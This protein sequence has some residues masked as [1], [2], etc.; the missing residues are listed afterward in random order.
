MIVGWTQ[1]VVDGLDPQRLKGSRNL[2]AASRQL[3]Y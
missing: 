1:F 3:E 2:S